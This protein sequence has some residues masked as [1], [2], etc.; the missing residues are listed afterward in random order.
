MKYWYWHLINIESPACSYAIAIWLLYELSQ[1]NDMLVYYSI[2]YAQSLQIKII[3][4]KK[5]V[6]KNLNIVPSNCKSPFNYYVFAIISFLLF[7]F[8]AVGHG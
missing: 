4:K 3:M 7:G 6:A 8:Q 1:Y 2:G 5:N